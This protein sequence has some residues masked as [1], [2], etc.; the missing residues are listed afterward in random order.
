MKPI[1]KKTGVRR[2]EIK[3]LFDPKAARK[4]E[5]EAENALIDLE[6]KADKVYQFAREIYLAQDEKTRNVVECMVETMKDMS[7]PPN[8]KFRGQSYPA[9]MTRQQFVQDKLFTSFAIRL[10]TACALWDIQVANFKLPQDRC[11]KCGRPV[12]KPTKKR[13]V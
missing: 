1:K 3:E 2:E 10:L 11:A 12:K 6:E 8:F 7:G 5:R 4:F 13:R 9:D